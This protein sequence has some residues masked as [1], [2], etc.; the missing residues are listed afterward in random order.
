MEKQTRSILAILS[1]DIP[2]YTQ[3]TEEDESHAF[4]LIAKHRD[5]INKHVGSSNG[6]P[7]SRATFVS[8]RYH[9]SAI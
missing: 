8:L 9:S 3:K 5:I 1:T 4:S 6:A 2:E 7:D